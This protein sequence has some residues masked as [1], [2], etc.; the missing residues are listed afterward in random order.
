MR[1]STIVSPRTGE[2]GFLRETASFLKNVSLG[3]RVQ[4]GE[5]LS[6]LNSKRETLS[7]SGC[8]TVPNVS[9]GADDPLLGGIEGGNWNRLSTKGRISPEIVW[10]KR[11]ELLERDFRMRIV[12][13]FAATL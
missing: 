8:G 1:L 7:E 9:K 2:N 11:L 5:G 4:T 6:S 10:L 3:S 12:S 13:F